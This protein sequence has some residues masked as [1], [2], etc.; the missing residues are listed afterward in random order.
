[1]V[2]LSSMFGYI[3]TLRSMTSGRGNFT[4]EFHRY[5][6]VPANVA[7]DIIKARS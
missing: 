7:E 5:D 1:V 6:I 3:G 2:P 4:M